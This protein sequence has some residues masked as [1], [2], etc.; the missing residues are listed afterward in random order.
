MEG[1]P[2]SGIYV[3]LLLVL[4]LGAGLLLIQFWRAFGKRIGTPMRTGVGVLL[5]AMW[6][7]VPWYYTVGRKALADAEVRELCAKDGGVKVYETVTL[8]PEKFD[9]YGVVR[10]PAKEKATPQDEYYYEWNIQYLRKGNPEMSRSWFRII[11]RNDEKVMGESIT[12][13]RGG[14]DLPG[15]WHRS[16]YSCPDPTER[17]SLESSMFLKGNVK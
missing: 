16:S 6:V 8:P 3:L 7:G 14:G 17:A 1:S 15:P 11:R 9:K 10:I 4:W 5:L 12:Y 13:S 2:V